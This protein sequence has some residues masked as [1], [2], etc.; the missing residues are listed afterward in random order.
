VTPGEP[1]AGAPGPAGPV[2]VLEIAFGAFPGIT[3]LNPRFQAGL[4][5]I[6]ATIEIPAGSL[7]GRPRAS[8]IAV[9]LVGFLP[10]LSFHR[11]CGGHPLEEGFFQDGIRGRCSAQED[12]PGVDIAHLIEHVTIDVQHFIGRMRLCS[13]ITCAWT[14]PRD[15][16][17]IFVESAEETTG[18]TSLGLAVDL[19]SELVVGR[20]PDPRW[21]R[22]MR[23]A[24]LARD[25]AGS[26]VALR[27]VPLEK[28]WGRAAVSEAIDELRRRGFLR[29]I[30]ASVNF[31][32]APILVFATEGKEP[33][34]WC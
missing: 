9:L 13:G 24:R 31:S 23:V 6:K 2:R 25:H 27:T 28:K 18:R 33:A 14:S 16:Y 22:L 20:P 8:A 10:S 19:V 21:L 32:G 11:C 1:G 29:E 4:D 34:A 15:R 17:D 12:D 30:P 26:P 7:E 5:R 3:A